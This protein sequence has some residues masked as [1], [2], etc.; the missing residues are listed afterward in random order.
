MHYGYAPYGAPGFMQPPALPFKHRS[1]SGHDEMPSSDPIESM[2]DVTLFPRLEQW[3]VDLDNSPH[4]LDNHDFA[5]FSPD[6]LR[7]KYMRIS[8]LDR[9]T[10]NELLEICGGMARG[11]AKKVLECAARECKVIRKKE[12]QRLQEM[13]KCLGIITDNIDTLG[14]LQLVATMCKPSLCICFSYR[15]NSFIE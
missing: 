9:L 1:H 3:L 6:F 11:T 4:G 14:L 12:K 13:E 2:E 8:D 7:E 5:S 10:V 15:P